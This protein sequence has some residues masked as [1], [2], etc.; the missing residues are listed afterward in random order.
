MNRDGRLEAFTHWLRNEQ[1][2]TTDART[3]NVQIKA[4]HAGCGTRTD[5]L[6]PAKQGRRV[7]PAHGRVETLPGLLPDRWFDETV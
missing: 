3:R 2:D 5:T 6:P 4:R 7:S 1:K